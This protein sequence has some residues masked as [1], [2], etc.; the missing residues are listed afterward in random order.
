VMVRPGGFLVEDAP[1]PGGH[2]C[3]TA[4]Q[5]EEITLHLPAGTAVDALPNDVAVSAGFATFR[6]TW[7]H[8]ADGGLVVRRSFAVAA[9]R[10]LCTEAEYQ[11]MRPALRA[12]RIDR[13]TQVALQ[14]RPAASSPA[15]SA[16]VAS[17][18]TPARGPTLAAA[19]GPGPAQPS[20]DASR[21]A[22]PPAAVVLTATTRS[23]A[24]R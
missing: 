20:S 12:A 19:P 8:G 24:K 17:V 15:A 1:V 23:S 4:R 11:A 21:A 13:R 10:P 16:P 6:A 14:P 5:E 18:G 7:R 3:L 2:V 22:L 9:P